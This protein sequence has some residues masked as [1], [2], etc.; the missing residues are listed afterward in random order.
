MATL[1]W[2]GLAADIAVSG[3][4]RLATLVIN[5]V[6][7]AVGDQ[8]VTIPLVIG[9]VHINHRVVQGSTIT[10]RALF[11]DLPGTT[12]DVVLAE[13]RAGIACAV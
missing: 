10:Q 3:A 6:P 4:S 11:V 5:G 13:S 12:L 1:P 2:R 9:A 8:P 7:R